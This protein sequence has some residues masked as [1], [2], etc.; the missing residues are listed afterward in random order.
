[1]NLTG[2]RIAVASHINYRNNDVTSVLLSI[3]LKLQLLINKM[4]TMESI[5]KRCNS[6]DVA[7]VRVVDRV[8]DVNDIKILDNR[9]S[10][11]SFD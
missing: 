4:G 11:K 6:S 8:D 3:A 1:M 7:N 10:L 9:F 2:N 5:F